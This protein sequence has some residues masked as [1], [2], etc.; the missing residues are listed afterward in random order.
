MTNHRRRP[1]CYA[2]GLMNE[3]T[4][5]SY[6][7]QPDNGL[8]NLLQGKI[9]VWHLPRDRHRLEREYACWPNDY[10]LVALIEAKCVEDAI[11]WTRDEWHR[12]E[13]IL[14]LPAGWRIAP[15]PTRGPCADLIQPRNTMVGDVLATPQG[16]AYLVEHSG[17]RRLY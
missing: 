3:E 9:Q 15:D 12:P 6:E 4:T 17:L 5:M 16:E 2:G 14:M 8:D 10:Q 11:R 1:S 7:E 13:V